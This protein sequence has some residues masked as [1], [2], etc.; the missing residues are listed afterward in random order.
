V[1]AKGE[2]MVF[3]NGDEVMKAFSTG[4]AHL[5]AK[6]KVRLTEVVNLE[7]GEQQR[8]AMLVDTTVGRVILYSIVP[9]G[10]PFSLVNQKMAK[11]QISH[12]I[13]SCYRNVGLK[14]TVIFADQLMCM[15]Y[16][17][18]TWSG[19]SI[20]VDD[21][22]IPEETARIIGAADTEVAE[23]ESQFAAGLVTQ[24]EK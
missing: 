13:N 10:L 17:Y 21:F 5:Q 8:N 18:S 23:I 11:K 16:R 7:N 22:V 3:A 12:I 4:H 9:E 2:G 1:N 14:E 6:I 24:G 20:G 19:S 15:G